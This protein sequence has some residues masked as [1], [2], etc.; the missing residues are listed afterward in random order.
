M[1]SEEDTCR[2]R[3]HDVDRALRAALAEARDLPDAFACSFARLALEAA[4]QRLRADDPAEAR[5]CLDLLI[6]RGGQGAE[7]AVGFADAL[8]IPHDAARRTDPPPALDTLSRKTGRIGIESADEALRR[9]SRAEIVNEI[10]AGGAVAASFT[11]GAAV[12]KAKL[13]ATT[14]REKNRMDTETERLRIASDERI[15]G[16]QAR[17]GRQPLP[18]A[19]ADAEDD[20]E[21]DEPGA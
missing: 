17:S 20:A 4:A 21:D 10:L 14:Q 15:A 12:L 11:A 9:Q 16:L 6:G 19:D 1:V 8:G 13:E 3:R 5:E 2:E 18:A 7:I